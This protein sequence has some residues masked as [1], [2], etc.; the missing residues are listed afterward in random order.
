MIVVTMS[1]SQAITVKSLGPTNTK[2]ARLRVTT[3]GGAFSATYSRHAFGD[4]PQ[5][6]ALAK[7]L[8]T[9]PDAWR[10]TEWLGG[11]VDA[12]T[13]VFIASARLVEG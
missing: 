7:F 11:Y 4:E 5:T 2:P 12:D 8:A 10:R 1:R 6:E 13:C 3:S 9:L